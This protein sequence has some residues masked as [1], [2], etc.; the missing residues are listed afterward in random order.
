VV[1]RG[2]ACRSPAKGQKRKR[3]G[4]TGATKGEIHQQR[5]LGGLD[6]DARLAV[7]TS[8]AIHRSRWGPVDIGLERRYPELHCGGPVKRVG[9]A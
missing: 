5:S 8:H 2:I 9:E 4:A 3:Q 6:P 7:E 1:K